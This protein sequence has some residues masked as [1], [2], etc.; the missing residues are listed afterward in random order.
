[1][2]GLPYEPSAR[3]KSSGEVPLSHQVSSVEEYV[4]KVQVQLCGWSASM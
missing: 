1:M 4:D 2:K 3:V